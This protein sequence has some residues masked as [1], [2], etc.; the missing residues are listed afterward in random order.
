[1]KN[2]LLVF[3]I[4][5][6]LLIIT[7]CD[8]DNPYDNSQNPISEQLVE[9]DFENW[10]VVT[11]GHISFLRPGGDWWDGLNY[12][13]V[14]GGPITVERTSDAF[15][16]NYALKL[17]TKLWGDELSIP[18]ILASG[19]FDP[20]LPV[21]ENL[22]IGKPFTK[23]PKSFEGYYKYFPAN[24]DTMVIFL[25][26]TK[27]NVNL[28]VRDTIARGEF[29]NNIP[30]DIYTPFSIPINYLVDQN[31]DSIHVILL[32]SVSG[33]EFKGHPG[34]VLIIDKLSLKYD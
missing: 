12:L 13:S 26:L 6:Y 20:N 23:K 5:T 33:K 14:I 3:S 18:G 1:M 24:N 21:G 15:S 32:T 22:V 7:S 9:G 16:G 25:A 27:Y 34:S 31:P 2:F 17:E 4:L 28:K 10:T 11:Q 19:H 8:G 29:T 30:K